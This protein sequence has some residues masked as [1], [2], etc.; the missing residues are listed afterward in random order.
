M[1]GI[2]IKKETFE[3]STSVAFTQGYVEENAKA[4]ETNLDV[5]TRVFGNRIIFKT[6]DA[7]VIM[8]LT[9]NTNGGTTIKEVR[10]SRPLQGT[11]QG[12]PVY[13]PPRTYQQIKD[14]R[15]GNGETV[16]YFRRKVT[17]VYR[18]DP[19]VPRPARIR[20]GIIGNFFAR[21]AED[22]VNK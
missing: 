4:I 2:F 5:K 10:Y 22:K 3:S 6:D 21:K 19:D 16:D 7:I 18:P 15:L 14:A 1:F 9:G 8:T 17:G 13:G 12:R 20:P 11:L